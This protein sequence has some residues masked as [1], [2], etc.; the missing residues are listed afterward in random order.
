MEEFPGR[1]LL[2]FRD[3]DNNNSCSS[4]VAISNLHLLTLW[5]KVTKKKDIQSWKCIGAIREGWNAITFQTKIKNKNCLLK[6]SISLWINVPIIPKWVKQKKNTYL[7]TESQ[8]VLHQSALLH[9]SVLTWWEVGS[10]L[11]IP[12]IVKRLWSLV[13]PPVSGR[14]LRMGQLIDKRSNL[15][16]RKLS[17]N[18]VAKCRRGRRPPLAIWLIRRRS[19][20]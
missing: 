5:M 4:A 1:W 8:R 14:C 2:W 16:L 19:L 18:W 11:P 13:S 6:L 9:M 17:L 7:W 12:L 20:H 10:S 15:S 3:K